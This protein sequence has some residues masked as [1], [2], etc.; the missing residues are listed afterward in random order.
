MT[1]PKRPARRRPQ[2]TPP[3]A[4][5]I[6]SS[7]EPG[8]RAH[9]QAAVALLGQLAL[10]GADLAVLMDEAAHHSAT[11]LLVEF[12][13]IHELSPDGT[14]FLTT[15]GV[16]WR[17]GV[18][19]H[20][21]TPAAPEFEPGYT[22][23]WGAPVLVEDFA[24]EDRFRPSETLRVHRVASGMSVPIRAGDRPFGV[25]AVYSGGLREFDRD[26]VNY[27][28]SVA[29]VLAAAIERHR[30]EE[31]LRAS[32]AR[33]RLLFESN[34][35][36]MWVYDRQT[37]RFL[38][39]NETAVRHYRYSR[40]E[41]LSMTIKDLRPPEDLPAVKEVR[42][43]DRDGVTHI[44]G[45]WRHQRKDGTIIHVEIVTHPLD[46]EGRPAEL[47]LVR[48]VTERLEMERRL[49]QSERLASM[50]RL[51]AYVAHEI[52]TPLANISL[53]AAS[54]ARRVQDKE[55]LEKLEK[56]NVQRRNAANI[57][58]DLLTFSKEREVHFEDVDLW[59]VVDLAAEATSCFRREGVSLTT[60]GVRPA[61]ASVDASQLRE[62]VVNLLKN[63]YEATATGSVTIRVDP[64][65]DAVVLAVTDTGTGI[66]PD[67]LGRIFEP[68]FTTKKL[69]EGTGIGLALCQ[70]IVGAHGGRIEVASEVGSG[71]EFRV[72]LPRKGGR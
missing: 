14:R 64:R 55:V 4:R 49:T 34:P 35:H 40:E 17:E 57:I 20:H 7:S 5:E 27:L 13:A 51:S 26:D 60:A 67:V 6:A 50:G 30:A 21:V 66:P 32:E 71:T 58:G 15:A 41:F 48:D 53:L 1:R 37:L 52:S 2:P 62:V 45:V 70:V 29:N 59:E 9:Q 11:Q 42:R 18:V 12:A 65:P 8:G 39:V 3:A 56:I 33:Y 23:L 10:A 63:A 61:P 16:G 28:Q 69:G 44:P 31:G 46:F 19:G 72:I 68:F 25:L 43:L 22:L 24:R 47:V 38:A 54:I 36:P